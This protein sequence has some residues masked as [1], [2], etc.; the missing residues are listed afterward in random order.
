MLGPEMNFKHKVRGET[1]TGFSTQ[2]NRKI[3][4]VSIAP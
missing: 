4:T 1:H 3:R 2:T